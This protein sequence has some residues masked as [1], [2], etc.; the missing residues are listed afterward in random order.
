L[1]RQAVQARGELRGD[2]VGIVRIVQPDNQVGNAIA[3]QQALRGGQRDA[4]IAVIHFLE[5]GIDDADDLHVDSIERAVGSDGQNRK[6][7]AHF[8]VHRARDTGANQ[9]FHF[10]AGFGVEVSSRAQAGAEAEA[11]LPQPDRRRCP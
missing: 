7:I 3:L 4:Q 8:D 10:A 1:L 9:R 2:H 11:A 6:P 5:A